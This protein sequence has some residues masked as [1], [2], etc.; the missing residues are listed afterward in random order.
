MDKMHTRLKKCDCYMTL[1][2]YHSAKHDLCQRTL[3][4]FSCV[5][6]KQSGFPCWLPQHSLQLAGGDVGV[7]ELGNVQSVEGG[8]CDGWRDPTVTQTI[9]SIVTMCSGQC[10]KIKDNN[11]SQWSKVI[12]IWP[13]VISLSS[14]V[15]GQ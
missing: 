8:P 10:L 2:L 14:M 11:N 9:W 15:N 1:Y 5:L 13:M 4:A 6:S 3:Q 7:A 12:S